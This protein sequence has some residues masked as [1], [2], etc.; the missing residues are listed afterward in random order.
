M[1]IIDN[2]GAGR[3]DK[4]AME[5]YSTDDMAADTLGVMDALGIESAHIHGISMGGAIAQKV[6]IRHPDRVRSLILTSTFAKMDVT[7]RRAI[8]LLRDACGQVDGVTLGRLCQWII[9]AHSFMNENEQYI[10]DMETYDAEH[11]D[12]PM[13]VYAYKAQ[14]NACLGHDTLDE[15]HKISCPTL[16]ASG[17]NDYFASVI[18]PWTW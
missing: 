4:P 16:I 10:L 1:R 2:R 3:S 15:L 6:T 9:Y 18:S 7:F 12:S 14:C 17:D 5:G 13:P 8:E 11:D